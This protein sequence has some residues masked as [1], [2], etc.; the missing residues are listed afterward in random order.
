MRRLFEARRVLEEIRY[1]VGNF[2]IFCH[3]SPADWLASYYLIV[4]YTFSLVGSSYPAKLLLMNLF[5]ISRLTLENLIVESLEKFTKAKKVLL[6]I[7]S[8]N[9]LKKVAQILKITLPAK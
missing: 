6:T 2:L 1:I 3:Y 5:Y 7:I 9:M 8:R 4:L